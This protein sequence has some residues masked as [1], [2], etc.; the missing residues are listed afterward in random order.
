MYFC[1][2]LLLLLT[3]RRP[4]KRGI[5]QFFEIFYLIWFDKIDRKIQAKFGNIDVLWSS[6]CL[7]FVFTLNNYHSVIN[8]SI[9]FRR[10]VIFVSLEIY[11]MSNVVN[12][13]LTLFWTASILGVW[14][15][16]LHCFKMKPSSNVD[17][18]ATL[19]YS[20]NRLNFVSKNCFSFVFK[21]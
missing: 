15:H 14:F 19:L 18:N 4:L 8:L 2:Q 20:K 11:S 12:K 10:F 17:A 3:D 9:V 7:T 5:R 1:R 6:G 21:S 16:T 13:W